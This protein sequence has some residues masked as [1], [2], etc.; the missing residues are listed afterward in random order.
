VARLKRVDITDLIRTT[1]ARGGSLSLSQQMRSVLEMAAAAGE[2]PD[3]MPLPSVRKL[4][5]ELKLAP[6][7]VVRAYKQLEAEGIVAVSPRR[8]YYVVGTPQHGTTPASTQVQGLID[9]ALRAAERAGL[10][11]VQFLQL[12]SKLI[13]AR[14]DRVER[15]AVVGDR[16]AALETR[17][18]VIRRALADLPVEVIP[19]SF[20]DLATP[21]GS[22][23]A[24]AVD[25]YVVPM[26]DTVRASALL[27]PHAYRILPMYLTL[28]DE[29]RSFIASRS[30]K[31]RFGIVVSRDIYRA[32]LA[33]AV[34]RIHSPTARISTA[35]V[36]NRAA[37]ERVVAEADVILISSPARPRMPATLRLTKPT[38]EM[39]FLPDDET[40]RRL[41]AI[42][43]A[44]AP[45]R[46]RVTAD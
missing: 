39:T 35:S 3:G 44:D 10:D 1:V 9:E 19:L 41:R 16:D 2:L 23:L 42:V 27:G 33:T 17:V 31:T 24:T 45:R 8:A 32:R 28:N 38:M 15:V 25:Y 13:K 12:V 36:D 20:E 5:G 40:I 26:L 43:A 34:R 7:T 21:A 14:R 6:N 29:V 37:V 22:L 11:T 46:P 18:N 30:A 4:A